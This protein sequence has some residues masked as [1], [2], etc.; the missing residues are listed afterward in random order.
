MILCE[1][2]PFGV[3]EKSKT[4]EMTQLQTCLPCTVEVWRWLQIW[5][6]TKKSWASNRDL[7]GTKHHH[8]TSCRISD[9]PLMYMLIHWLFWKFWS[10]QCQYSNRA[11]RNFQL[12]LHLQFPEHWSTQDW[13]RM[14]W[15]YTKLM[16]H[17][18]LLILTFITAVFLGLEIAFSENIVV[19]RSSIVEALWL[20]TWRNPELILCV[21]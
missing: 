17:S 3:T 16:K 20:W 4:I 10:N 12:R 6:Y 11:L 13:A 14:M 18:R 21:P 7:A 15:T 9:M 1:W 2:P 19:E 8:I 5:H